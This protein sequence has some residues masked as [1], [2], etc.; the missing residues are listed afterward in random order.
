[1]VFRQHFRLTDESA[2]VGQP[3]LSVERHDGD[4]Q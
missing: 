1:M 3:G 4:P 2:G